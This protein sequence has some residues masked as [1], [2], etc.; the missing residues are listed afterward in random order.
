M[1][2]SD[3]ALI[4]III[5]PPRHLSRPLSR[6]CH[7]IEHITT[8]WGEATKRWS[9][10]FLFCRTAP[11]SLLSK[12]NVWFH[13][14]TTRLIE[15]S[16]KASTNRGKKCVLS[17]PIASFFASR[18]DGTEKLVF[19]SRSFASLSSPSVSPFWL[20]SFRSLSMGLWLL[21]LLNCS[22]QP[23]GRPCCKTHTRLS[24]EEFQLA[25]VSRARSNFSLLHILAGRVVRRSD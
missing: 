13:F 10:F 2:T 6:H 11:N 19:S 12:S 9:F 3:A 7:K 4:T 25:V 1:Y 22:P 24:S 21:P 16:L 18:H 5:V 17:R 20:F 14:A 15:W 8:M 23:I